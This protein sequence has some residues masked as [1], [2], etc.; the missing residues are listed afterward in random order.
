MTEKAAIHFS[1]KKI[2][3]EEGGSGVKK[4]NPGGRHGVAAAVG[5]RDEG[6]EGLDLTWQTM[7]LPTFR[8]IFLSSSWANFCFRLL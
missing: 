3:R 4:K 1:K 2:V 6:E 8:S 7:Y 5:F